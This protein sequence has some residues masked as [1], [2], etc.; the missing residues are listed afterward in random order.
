MVFVVAS[1]N[2]GCMML[3]LSITTTQHNGWMDMDNTNNGTDN[4][5]VI[6]PATTP[7]TATAV[8]PLAPAR[9]PRKPA[10]TVRA[11]VSPGNVK[12]LADVVRVARTV[13]VGTFGVTLA[14]VNANHGVTHAARNVGRFTRG[15]I[16]DVQ[17]ETLRDN[18]TWKLDDVQLL[19]VWRAEFPMASGMVF[20]A[21]PQ[22]GV[23]IVRGVR[24]DYNRAPGHH[25][26]KFAVSAKSER[27]GAARFDWPTAGTP[28]ASTR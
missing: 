1:N 11:V 15:R 24:A 23:E 3:L 20:T 8:A 13:T 10:K 26:A 14:A 25:G 18:A 2:G 19:F 27:Y 21:T 16:M 12:T 9:K 4:G 6:V 7:D 22:R 17:N 28:V 5:T